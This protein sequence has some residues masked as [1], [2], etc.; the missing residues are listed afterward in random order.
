MGF[1][2]APNPPNWLDSR[3]ASGPAELS[4]DSL[5]DFP[6]EHGIKPGE[7]NGSNPPP[8]RR[9]YGIPFE[10]PLPYTTGATRVSSSLESVPEVRVFWKSVS[11]RGT[12]YSYSYLSCSMEV[13]PECG[14]MTTHATSKSSELGS[15]QSEPVATN[16]C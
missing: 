13:R 5:L 9:T 3:R 2:R 15:H 8:V 16:I 10:L 14:L 7:E 11:P 6:I 1:A 4:R 12:G